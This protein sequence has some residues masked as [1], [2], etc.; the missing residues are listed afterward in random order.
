VRCLDQILA[1]IGL[2]AASLPDYGVQGGP[3]QYRQFCAAVNRPFVSIVDVV[4]DA[5]A[6]RTAA[7]A[8]Q[9]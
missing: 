1:Q 3:C 6:A 7:K 9:A 8:R 5:L 2:V 4:M